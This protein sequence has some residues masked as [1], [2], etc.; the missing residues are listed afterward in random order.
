M[1]FNEKKK[2]L[3]IKMIEDYKKKL[4]EIICTFNEHQKEIGILPDNSKESLEK[5]KEVFSLMN[6]DY[7]KL[8]FLIKEIT[9]KIKNANS[10]KKKSTLGLIGSG[11]LGIAGIAGGI[12]VPN[13]FSIVYGISGILNTFAA[14]GHKSTINESQELVKYLM[15]ILEEA[16]NQENKIYHVMDD[17]IMKTSKMNEQFPNFIE[18]LDIKN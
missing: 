17:L 2:F 10:H 1:I 16:I 6:Q 12:I 18:Y 8:K 13:G 7:K 9:E 3:P 5:I 11:I 15:N 4:D 14:V